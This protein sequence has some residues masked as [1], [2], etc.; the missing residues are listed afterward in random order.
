MRSWFYRH[1]NV[2]L[3]LWGLMAFFFASLGWHRFE[4]HSWALGVI[5]YLTAFLSMWN[6]ITWWERT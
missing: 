4:Q 5:D 1:P 3:V 6:A 2:P